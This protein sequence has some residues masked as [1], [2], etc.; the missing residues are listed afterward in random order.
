M[1]VEVATVFVLESRVGVVVDSAEENV[2]KSLRLEEVVRSVV[3]G[4]IVVEV[5]GSG[6]TVDGSGAVVTEVLSCHLTRKFR[7]CRTIPGGSVLFSA[8]IMLC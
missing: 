1:V 2:P 8:V 5:P 3:L 7:S 4:V 6:G